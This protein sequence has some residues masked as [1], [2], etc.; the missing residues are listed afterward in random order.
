MKAKQYY[1]K[2]KSD[3]NVGKWLKRYFE[4][5]TCRRNSIRTE[6]TQCPVCGYYCLGNGGIG[7]IDKP[8]LIANKKMHRTQNSTGDLIR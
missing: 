6:D 2:H 7:C 5:R 4:K 3:S 1:K 8:A